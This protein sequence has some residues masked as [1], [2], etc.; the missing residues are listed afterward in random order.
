[1]DVA[2]GI[3]NLGVALLLAVSRRSKAPIIDF[4]EA[5]KAQRGLDGGEI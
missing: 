4:P 3:N 1:M 5:Q 2:A